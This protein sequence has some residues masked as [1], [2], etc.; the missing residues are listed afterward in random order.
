MSGLS[1]KER[2][3]CLIIA[4]LVATTGD[5]NACAP[6]YLNR[7]ASYGSD[8]ETRHTATFFPELDYGG[9]D[10][11]RQRGCLLFFC[12]R[13]MKKQQ[14]DLQEKWL[15][16]ADNLRAEASLIPAGRARDGLLHR[17]AQLERAISIEAALRT[18]GASGT[19]D[20]S[21]DRSPD[22]TP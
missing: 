12:V 2:T 4:R 7:G 8:S 13:P 11:A 21:A 19:L 6:P 9:R 14:S 5:E 20:P 15:A 3:C 1:A 17:V 10:D 16:L 22:R 18:D